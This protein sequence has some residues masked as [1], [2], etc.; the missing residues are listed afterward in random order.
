MGF[1]FIVI[2]TS[3]RGCALAVNDRRRDVRLPH[4]IGVERGHR[5]RAGAREV[6]RDLREVHDA[7][8]RDERDRER[9][10]RDADHLSAVIAGGGVGAFAFLSKNSA[11]ATADP[12]ASQVPPAASALYAALASVTPIEM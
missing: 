11:A 5:V 12:T 1:R 2:E 3:L 7:A 4:A 8:D 9:E 6:D 10:H